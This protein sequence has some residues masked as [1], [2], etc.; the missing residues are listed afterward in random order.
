[1]SVTVNLPKK[2]LY[3]SYDRIECKSFLPIIEKY[4][5]KMGMWNESCYTND[6]R[7]YACDMAE[8]YERVYTQLKTVAKKA[9][10]M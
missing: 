8:E 9:N 4:K 10:C 3:F 6:Y 2:S 1:M 7:G 5:L